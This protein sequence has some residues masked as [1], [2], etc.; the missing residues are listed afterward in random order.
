MLASW[1]DLPAAGYG[2]PRHLGPF[3]VALLRHSLPEFDV[4]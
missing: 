3:D 2:V 4:D 1:T